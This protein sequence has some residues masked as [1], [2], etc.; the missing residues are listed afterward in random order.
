MICYSEDMKF[1]LLIPVTFY[2]NDPK[3]TKKLLQE[4][5]M[6]FMYEQVEYLWID[7]KKVTI[8]PFPDDEDED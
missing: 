8:S 7:D 5:L 1:D 3:V 4:A 6:D 2:A